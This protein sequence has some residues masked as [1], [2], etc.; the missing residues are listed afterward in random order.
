MVL[1]WF[2]GT[3]YYFAKQIKIKN[4]VKLIDNQ[5][6]CAKYLTTYDFST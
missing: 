3:L 5:I 2:F 6:S 4:N 1:I